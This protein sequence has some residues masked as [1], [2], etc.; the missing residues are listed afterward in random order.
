MRPPV[1]LALFANRGRPL[2]R[3]WALAPDA[4]A[5]SSPM[6]RSTSSGQPVHSATNWLP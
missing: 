5:V 3:R 4:H 6:C 2:S 1:F